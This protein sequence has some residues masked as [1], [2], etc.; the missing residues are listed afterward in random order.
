MRWR[1]TTKGRWEPEWKKSR[2]SDER[3][4][5][6]PPGETVVV[7]TVIGS[8]TTDVGRPIRTRKPPVRFGI[9]EHVS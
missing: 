3:A 8:E 9:D 6:S 5:G 7:F 1:P 4:E 2:E